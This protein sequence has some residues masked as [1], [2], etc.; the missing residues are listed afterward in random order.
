MACSTRKQKQNARKMKSQLHL[1]GRKSFAGCVLGFV[2]NPGKFHSLKH[3]KNHNKQVDLEKSERFRF[4]FSKD[5]DA[6]TSL[7]TLLIHVQLGVCR[8]PNDCCLEAG[9]SAALYL[10]RNWRYFIPCFSYTIF[11]YPCFFL[12]ATARKLLKREYPEQ[13][14]KSSLKK[15]HKNKP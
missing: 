15:N 10:T 1:L 14:V 2:F 5:W 12:A 13:Q 4:F 9:K 3:A 7:G 8:D 6:L 11:M